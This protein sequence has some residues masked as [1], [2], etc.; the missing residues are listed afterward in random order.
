[1]IK[2]LIVRVKMIAY[3]KTVYTG[4]TALGSRNMANILTKSPFLTLVTLLCGITFSTPSHADHAGVTVINRCAYQTIYYVYISVA[5]T[6]S[7]G[8][9]QLKS[10]G[11]ISPYRSH[12]WNINFNPNG[13][14]FDLK[15]TTDV[16]NST[17]RR[18]VN[19][20]KGSDG[21]YPEWT[22]TC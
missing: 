17:E 4:W 12:T 13:C 18:R 6:S 15:A 14:Y 11:V 2:N 10:L 3:M 16:G 9:D 1:M 8:P 22:I 19:L 7:W 21:S 5:G 20:C